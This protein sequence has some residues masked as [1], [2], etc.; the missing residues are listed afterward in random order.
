MGFLKTFAQNLFSAVGMLIALALF[1]TLFATTS[2]QA[3][4]SQRI[5]RSGVENVDYLTLVG[6]AS[7]RA[8]SVNYSR[9]TTKRLELLRG[10]L[11]SSQTRLG[12]QAVDFGGA[13]LVHAN[14]IAALTEYYDCARS[15]PEPFN[16][17]IDSCRRK[18]MRGDDQDQS[19][20]SN[21][22]VQPGPGPAQILA[23]A[24]SK[25]EAY[26]ASQATMKLA[27]IEV[28]QKKSSIDQFLSGLNSSKTSPGEDSR[29]S[30]LISSI[31]VDLEMMSDPT[32]ILKILVRIPPIVNSLFLVAISG[33]LGAFLIILFLSVFPQHGDL[34]LQKERGVGLQNRISLGALTAIVVFLAM[35]STT[36][37]LNPN[38]SVGGSIGSNALSL[39]FIGILAGAFSGKVASWLGVRAVSLLTGSQTI[40]SQSESASSPND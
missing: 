29:L 31:M 37:I 30:Q 25:R 7:E 21:P 10:D 33:A 9:E 19:E 12:A 4:V 26:F 5:E 8:S 17:E 13:S 23:N 15:G 20:S 3:Q 28:D 36:M 1:T 38:Q 40:D 18:Q 22:Q 14:A 35:G 39:S 2:F 6:R 34:V 16:V 27:E 11:Q 24:K 32:G